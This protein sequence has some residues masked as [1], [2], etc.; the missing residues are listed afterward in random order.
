M[1]R[2]SRLRKL[3]AGLARRPAP[4]EGA[5]QYPS[6][7]EQIAV[8]RGR[9][10]GRASRGLLRL[11]ERLLGPKRR[12][13]TAVR[14]LDTGQASVPAVAAAFSAPAAWEPMAFA[15]PVSVEPFGL[16]EPAYGRPS[17]PAPLPVPPQTRALTAP[18]E[19][20]TAGRPPMPARPPLAAT[21]AAA[22]G[23]SKGSASPKGRR[24]RPPRLTKSQQDSTEAFERDLAALL[25]EAKAQAPEDAAWNA[26]VGQAKPTAPAPGPGAEPPPTQ[27]LP[28]PGHG[29]FDQM[30]SAMRYA[31]SFDLGAVDLGSR[32]D[33]IE[34]ELAP[35][36][37]AA[38]PRPIA[39]ARSLNDFDVVAD[40]AEL[41]A[42]EKGP[43]ADAPPATALDIPVPERVASDSSSTSQETCHG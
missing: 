10:P 20:Q 14:R 37:P 26:T 32:F 30:G 8:V 41:G 35:P 18:L 15:G 29:I 25:G 36:A 13:E 24:S 11:E 16:G 31:N 40:L 1:N 6:V 23:A 2:A 12:P 5:N 39:E 21:A 42:P 43:S 33:A 34:Q 4:P 3:E 38:R 27:P 7:E 22:A 9:V 28:N 19:R 17:C